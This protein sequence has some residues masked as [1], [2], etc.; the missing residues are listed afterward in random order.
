MTWASFEVGDLAGEDLFFFNI[1]EYNQSVEQIRYKAQLSHF[2]RNFTWLWGDK[3]QLVLR[4]TD[5]LLTSPTILMDILSNQY[6]K[7]MWSQW[8]CDPLCC[9][10]WGRRRLKCNRNLVRIRQYSWRS[11]PRQHRSFSRLNANMVHSQMCTIG[12]LY[13]WNKLPNSNFWNIENNSTIFI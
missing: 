10:V 5:F 3:Y 1:M 9:A 8:T 7:G 2:L 6:L 13:G 4:Q 12:L 11:E